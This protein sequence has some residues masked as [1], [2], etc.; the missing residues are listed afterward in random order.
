MNRETIPHSQFT[1]TLPVGVVDGEGS[2]HREGVM[3]RVTGQDEI[4]VSKDPQT[5]EN[6]AYRIISLLSRVITHVGGFSS[7]TP[8]LLEQ[9]FL[10]DFLYLREF[11]TQI[12]RSG[13]EGMTLGEFKATP[14]SNCTKR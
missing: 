4:W 11:Y 12:N 6:P 2:L 7:V 5:Q 1:F 3:R 8:E 9:L 14:W 10:R 13:V